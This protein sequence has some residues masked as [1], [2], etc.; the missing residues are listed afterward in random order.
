MDQ[1]VNNINTATMRALVN[2]ERERRE[3]FAKQMED[4]KNILTDFIQRVGEENNIQV[5]ES[6][7]TR[8]NLVEVAKFAI[9]LANLIM[10]RQKNAISDYASTNP[11]ELKARIAK[12]EQENRSL[13]ILIDAK[14]TRPVPV[15]VPANQPANTPAEASEDTAVAIRE[16]A[17]PVFVGGS[18]ED[19]VIHVAG[20]IQT[21]RL[22]G[23]VDACETQLGLPKAEIEAAIDNLISNKVI[24]VFESTRTS[25]QG[26]EFPKVFRL[27]PLGVKSFNESSVSEAIQN[28][29]GLYNNKIWRDETSLA[30]Y[31]FE[32]LLPRHGYSFVRY[33][34]EIG[35]TDANAGHIFTP[36]VQL[37]NPDNKPIYAMFAGGSYSK[38][39]VGNYLSDF[40]QA[41][42]G[43]VYFVALT[44][45][46]ARQIM[47]DINYILRG[48]PM[49]IHPH[50]SN[51]DDLIQYERDVTTGVT[52]KASSIWFVALKKNQ[53]E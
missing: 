4:T 10:I 52:R 43:H 37:L 35:V 3:R 7:K 38:G 34:P 1:P 36:H 25:R 11:E 15:V 8:L 13:K 28:A 9:D 29:V 53:N 39:M 26:E 22:G 33:L 16:S 30:A 50:V 31:V 23:L 14:S 18:I 48:K 49:I 24:D 6:I 51:L 27:T 46:L 2:A 41:D 45:R 19:Q 42:N 44:A 12:L 20:S 40:A 47:S 17:A 5:P 32:E 21:I